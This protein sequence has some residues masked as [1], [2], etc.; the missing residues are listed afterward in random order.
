INTTQNVTIN[1]TAATIGQR[2]LAFGTDF[3]I[4]VAYTIVIM[5]IVYYTGLG[6]VIKNLD[7]WSQRALQVL[8]FIPI[9]F[10]SLFFESFLEGQ[11]LG[12]RLLKIKVVKIDGYQASFGDYLIR[13]LFRLID[14]VIG[15]GMIGFISIVTN[16]NSQRLGDMAAG[17]AI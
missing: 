14:I 11:S 15:F 8:F 2:I 3:L 16:R 7:S 17:T 4:Q 10:Y 5:L 12:K 9:T 1:F 13:W 6:N